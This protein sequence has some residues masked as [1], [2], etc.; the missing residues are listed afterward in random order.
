MSQSP[1]T[2][3]TP[4]KE[5]SLLV[6]FISVLVV[7]HFLFTLAVPIAFIYEIKLFLSEN[8]FYIWLSQPI[9]IALCLAV[10]NSTSRACRML[11]YI[12]VGLSLLQIGSVFFLYAIVDKIG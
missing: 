8:A 12:D 7:V 2:A 9:L 4:P 10:V 6:A 3:G 5:P 1:R 11:L